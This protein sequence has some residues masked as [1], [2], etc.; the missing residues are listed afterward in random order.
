MI[1]LSRQ[2]FTREV[3][4]LSGKN[5]AT[6]L[7]NILEENYK[8]HLTLRNCSE[9]RFSRAHE[10]IMQLLEA[11][12]VYRDE[13]IENHRGDLWRPRYHVETKELQQNLSISTIPL[14]KLQQYVSEETVLKEITLHNSSTMGLKTLLA[15]YVANKI[16]T[17][18]FANA[19]KKLSTTKS[20]SK[21]A[22]LIYTKKC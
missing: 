18:N 6:V 19:I 2:E 1:Q 4:P 7:R 21:I 13:I 8:K 22:F 15:A 20:E 10:Y 17:S 11:S 5:D 9:D 3:N 14:Q 16:F 12:S